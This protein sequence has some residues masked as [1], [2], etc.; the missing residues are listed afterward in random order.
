MDSSG[1]VP[2]QRCSCALRTM[3]EVSCAL[4][5]R[6]RYVTAR[7]RFPHNSRSTSRGSAVSKEPRRTRLQRH[8]IVFYFP[9]QHRT[10][11]AK[12]DARVSPSSRLAGVR[13]AASAFKW[14]PS[15]SPF[16]H[17]LFVRCWCSRTVARWLPL[18]SC[19]F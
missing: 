11:K 17:W 16:T 13:A 1:L 15:F 6:M 5:T 7:Q 3:Q 19:L 4:I 14:P 18:S 2:F 8:V 9:R 12:N 10:T